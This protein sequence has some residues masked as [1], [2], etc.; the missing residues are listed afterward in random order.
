MTK[1]Y[2]MYTVSL[3]PSNKVIVDD[4]LFNHSFFIFYSL[5]IFLF[6]FRLSSGVSFTCE[7]T[8]VSASY[9]VHICLIENIKKK[10]MIY[11]I[12]RLVF[13]SSLYSSPFQVMTNYI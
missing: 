7:V 3:L 2:N 10:K 11:D 4:L 9:A 6:F 1:I 8:F 13:L 5:R 12:L